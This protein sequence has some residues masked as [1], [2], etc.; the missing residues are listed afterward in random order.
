MLATSAKSQ[1]YAELSTG[2]TLRPYIVISSGLNFKYHNIVGGV[3]VMGISIQADAIYYG[4]KGGYAFTAGKFTISPEAA[5]YLRDYGQ[6]GLTVNTIVEKAVLQ[7]YKLV[8]GS[9]IKIAYK[10]FFI[11]PGELPKHKI[12][13]IG[14]DL[15]L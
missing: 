12:F 13:K 1:V 15:K 2:T 3:E 7:R 5:V 11:E 10:E 6:S 14:V 4:L 8:Y 9:F